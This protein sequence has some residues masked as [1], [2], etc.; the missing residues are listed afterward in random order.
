MSDIGARHFR[1]A[2][3]LAGVRRLRELRELTEEKIAIVEEAT[4]EAERCIV[5]TYDTWT[6]TAGERH[7]HV[8]TTTVSVLRG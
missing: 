2:W 3:H 7:T 4:G 5:A 6:T 8:I 1:S